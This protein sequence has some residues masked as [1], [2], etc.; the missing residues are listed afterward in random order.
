MKNKYRI[1]SIIPFLVASTLFL[2]SVI[3]ILLTPDKVN[4]QG[5]LLTYTLPDKIVLGGTGLLLTLILILISKIQWKYVFA[6][7]LLISIF[8]LTQFYLWIFPYEIRITYPSFEIN[9]S[10]ELT[11]LFL[12]T[13]H[14]LLNKD[15]LISVKKLIDLNGKDRKNQEPKMEFEHNRAV[16]RF[17]HQFRDKSKAELEQIVSDGKHIPT[18]IEAANKLLEEEKTC[19]NNGEYA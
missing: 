3:E 10:F 4:E 5:E 13:G 19:H 1:I 11:A 7:L 15:I 16:E 17:L 9:L 12:L 6:V 18:A 14:I 8:Q 2:S